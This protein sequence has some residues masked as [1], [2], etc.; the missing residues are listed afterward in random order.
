[1][2]PYYYLWSSERVLLLQVFGA[3]IVGP[4]IERHHN[5]FFG[6]GESFLFS[7][8]PQAQCFH[9][10]AETDLILRANDEEL[11]VGSGG[12]WVATP[13]LPFP[14]SPLLPSSLNHLFITL[15]LSS[16][17][18]VQGIWF[19]VGWRAG[20]RKHGHMHCIQQCPT[21]WQ[22]RSGLQVCCS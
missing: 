3:F 17:L 8:L 16:Y 12:G 5:Q 13:S 15:Y 6:S 9:W 18:M 2:A 20:Q 19:V 1:M 21:H 11:I 7:L 10:S 14:H 22:W 4:L